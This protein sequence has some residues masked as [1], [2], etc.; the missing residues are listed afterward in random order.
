[1]EG[2]S[3]RC[4]LRTVCPGSPRQ[5]LRTSLAERNRSLRPSR[6]HP[7][8]CWRWRAPSGS[9]SGDIDGLL[10]AQPQRR[11]GRGWPLHLPCEANDHAG[12][13]PSTAHA[14]GW[15]HGR[16]N[17]CCRGGCHC[18][19]HIGGVAWP[20]RRGCLLRLCKHHRGSLHRGW[21]RH[22]LRLCQHHWRSLQRG[23]RRHLRGRG[24]LYRREDLP[25]CLHLVLYGHRSWASAVLVGNRLHP[26]AW[27]WLTNWTCSL[28]LSRCPPCATIQTRLRRQGPSRSALHVSAVLGDASDCDQGGFHGDH[29]PPHFLQLPV[30]SQGLLCQLLLQSQLLLLNQCEMRCKAATF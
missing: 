13:R 10:R 26:G 11:D 20:L 19:G 24:N 6:L 8:G 2:T 17:C 7:E 9:G 23:R 15:G 4:Q 30:V 28:R 3:R 18:R 22:L 16:T 12:R 27:W 14:G 25:G 21:R 5:L 29:L 1:M